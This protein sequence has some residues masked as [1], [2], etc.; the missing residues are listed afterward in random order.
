VNAEATAV[1]VLEWAAQAAGTAI[2]G[3]DIHRAGVHGTAGALADLPPAGP[4][5]EAAALARPGPRTLA[6]LGELARDTAARLGTGR[7]PFADTTPVGLGALLLAAA[8]GGRGEPE[9]ARGLAEATPRTRLE[10]THPDAG[11]AVAG[12]GWPDAV[13]RHGIVAPAL[14]A[15]PVRD[16]PAAPAGRA[17]AGRTPS[18]QSEHA[19]SGQ[20]ADRSGAGG[21]FRRGDIGRGGIDTD[22]I[23][24]RIDPALADAL[25]EASVLTSV[26]H[27]PAARRLAGGATATEVDAAVRLLGRPRGRWVFA[28]HL[29]RWSPDPAVLTW[30]AELLS[31]VGLDRPDVL[32]DV[33]Q[34]ARL[35]HG[36]DWDRRLRWAGRQLTGSDLPDNLPIATVKFWAPL[37]VLER[38]DA[39]TLRSRA[40]LD[41]HRP[42]LRLVH[43]H[44]LT[45]TSAL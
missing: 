17:S 12:V 42:A 4:L 32:L 23:R 1:R 5:R 6:A 31:R 26:L 38:R 37:A 14:A 18:G 21:S 40:L 28:A 33:Y 2:H 7:P 16:A 13:A 8:V 3:T 20:L 25:L 44:Q 45:R 22:R 39:G 41:G 36:D 35:R 29:S 15:L 27:R 34:T 10:E 24:D 9:A 19:V 11:P 43:R 30:R